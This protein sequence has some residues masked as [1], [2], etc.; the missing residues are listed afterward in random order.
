MGKRRIKR[1]AVIF[2]AV[3]FIGLAVGLFSGWLP[4][5]MGRWLKVESE[6]KKA[7]LIYVYGGSTLVRPAYAAELYRNN[8]APLVVTGGI[9]LNHELMALG[10]YYNDGYLNRRAVMRRGVPYDNTVKLPTGTSTYEETVGLK[11]FMKKNGH[12]SAI[13]VSSPFHMRRIR[14][15]A[16]TVFKDYDAELILAP[17]PEDMDTISLKYWW[18]EEEDFITITVEYIKLLYYVFMH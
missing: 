18:K 6:L 11:E 16:K 12:D 5:K 8:Y 17:V 1:I 2:F 7:D 3:L 10:L 14:Y 15:T 13:L 4:N 9:L